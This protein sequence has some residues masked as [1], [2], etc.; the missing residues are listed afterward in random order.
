MLARMARLT[1]I[2]KMKTATAIATRSATIAATG[3]FTLPEAMS[4]SRVTTGSAA[5]AVDKTA[6]SSGL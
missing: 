6:L 4:A 2:V 1:G 5:A 3:A